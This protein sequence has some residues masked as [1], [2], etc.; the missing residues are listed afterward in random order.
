MSRN[1]TKPLTQRQMKVSEEIRRIIAEMLTRGDIYSADFDFTKAVISEVR[2]SPDFSVAKV[3][4]SPLLA[5]SDMQEVIDN[6]Y[7]VKGQIKKILASKVRLRI[8]PDLTFLADTSFVYAGKIQDL[9]NSPEVKR[10]LE[11]Q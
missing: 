10:D 9:L 2:I 6:L 3:F 4:V 1:D 7:A 11:K 5:D 8:I